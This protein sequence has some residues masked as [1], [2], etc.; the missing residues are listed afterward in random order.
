M[1]EQ[2]MRDIEPKYVEYTDLLETPEMKEQVGSRLNYFLQAMETF[3]SAMGYEGKVTVNQAILTYAV[4]GYFT[5]VRRLKSF[6][7]IK[8]VNEFKIAA[9]EAQWLLSRRA[10][11][12]SDLNICFANEEFVLSHLQK[13]L[14]GGKPYETKVAVSQNAEIQG[15]HDSLYYHLKYRS[16]DAKNLELMLLAFRAGEVV[17]SDA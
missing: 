16:C 13:F 8:L 15:F 6:T 9:Y 7:H 2:G 3:I 1:T 14:Y 17:A 10:L 12:S 4:L 11:Q 5:D